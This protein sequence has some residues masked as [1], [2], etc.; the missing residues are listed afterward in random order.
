[1]SK[2]FITPVGDEGIYTLDTGSWRTF[3]PVML[4]E[5][6]TNCGLCMIFCPVGSITGDENKIY[7][8]GYQYCK[9]C[10]I[11]VRECPTKAIIMV[12]ES[13]E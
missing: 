12:R 5:K 10:G 2:K 9:G 4:K 11:R 7:E 6:C 8:I 1:M 13:I 3:K